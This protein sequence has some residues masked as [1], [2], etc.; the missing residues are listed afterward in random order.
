MYILLYIISLKLFSRP[1]F[2]TKQPF[3]HACKQLFHL[4]SGSGQHYSI[5][6]VPDRQ[7]KIRYLPVI[8]AVS[9]SAS[10]G[11]R[12]SSNQNTTPPVVFSTP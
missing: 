3:V 2:Q 5:T 1:W 8:T 10:T 7:Q 4:K 11:A 6:G 9:V 12:F